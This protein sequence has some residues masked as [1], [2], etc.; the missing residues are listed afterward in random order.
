M[1]ILEIRSLKSKIKD[2]SVK[3]FS[4]DE[5]ITVVNLKTELQKIEEKVNEFSKELIQT[6]KIVFTEDNNIDILAT[7]EALL[8]D[9]KTDEK[10]IL[11][12]GKEA[13]NKFLMADAKKGAEE[14]KLNTTLT[15]ELVT[16]INKNA[17]LT[18][19]DMEALLSIQN[20]AQEVI[21]KSK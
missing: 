19:L 13:I 8:S 18:L 10:E 11:K 6:N 3:D 21:E 1:K 17:N 4:Y 9:D 16:K 7:G 20:K 12:V 5:V 14:F 15:K 2:L